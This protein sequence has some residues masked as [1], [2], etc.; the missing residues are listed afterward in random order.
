MTPHYCGY[1][2][3]LEQQYSKMLMDEFKAMKA[4][5]GS[6]DLDLFAYRPTAE[7]AFPPPFN[8]PHLGLAMAISGAAASPNMGYYTSTPV[9]FLLTVFNVRLGQWLGNPRNRV[10]SGKPTPKFGLNC[11]MQELFAGTNDTSDYI[12]L[13]D[14]GHFDN[15]GLYEL[16]K[17][18]CGLIIVC[19]A[20]ADPNYGFEGLGNS[21]KR[22]RID[23]GIDI[24]IDTKPIVP[25]KSG[26]SKQ[27]YAIG[28]IHY[29]QADMYAPVGKIIYI[30][31]SL[32]GEEP[33]DVTTHK[34]RHRTFPHE[35]T[36]DQWFSESQF[37]SYRRLGHAA[38]A[39]SVTGKKEHGSGIV[40]SDV[41]PILKEFG[42]EI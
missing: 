27:H 16:V 14:G 4:G 20:E 40:I 18:R 31:A 37:E 24:E 8:G 21:I 25:N 2:V 15:L 9:A 38:L 10:T 22:C 1:D 28:K 17:R 7:Y 39:S 11:L 33:A 36:A 6:K 42:F 35:S 34:K 41:I 23:L 29:E 5:K 32:T 30:K 12:Y 13:S 3:F 19:D 26:M